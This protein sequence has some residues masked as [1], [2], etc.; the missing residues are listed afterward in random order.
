MLLLETFTIK[1]PHLVGQ[2]QSEHTT[3]INYRDGQTTLYENSY[4][5]WTLISTQT[6]SILFPVHVL[7]GSRIPRYLTIDDSLSLLDVLIL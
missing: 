3:L 7:S 5:V 6:S 2:G 1:R 4:G